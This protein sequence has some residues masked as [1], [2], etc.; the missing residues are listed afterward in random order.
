MN[1]H[2]VL[3]IHASLDLVTLNECDYFP[4]DFLD[5]PTKRRC[6]TVKAD[7]LKRLE[8]EY[9]GCVPQMLGDIVHVDA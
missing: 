4:F 1:R 7:R 6:H 9:D 8:V 2:L 5:T 3:A